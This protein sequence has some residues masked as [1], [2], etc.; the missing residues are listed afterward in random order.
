ME[1]TYSIVVVTGV[2]VEKNGDYLLCMKPAGVGPYPDKWITPGGGIEGNESL[3]E[4]AAREV[5][6]ETGIKVTNL[7]RVFF[8][9]FITPN[10]RG[11]T[12]QYVAVFYT[13]EYL[14]GVLGA[15]EGDD[16]N[17]AQMQ[18]F[19]KTELVELPLNPPLQRAL[20]HL[21]LL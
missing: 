4:C 17:M 7:K 6:E 16:D 14:S 18:W 2:L 19:S 20:R 3:D 8:D 9:D 11:N 1:R 21:E 15:T 5:Y 10:W 13:A 12:V